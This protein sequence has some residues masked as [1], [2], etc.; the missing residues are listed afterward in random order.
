MIRFLI[1]IVVAVL[2]LGSVGLCQFA[3]TSGLD[4]RFSREVHG[5]GEHQV[6]AATTEYE[7]VVTPSFDAKRDPF[8]LVDDG[9]GDAVRIRIAVEGHELLAWRE[10]V[11]RGVPIRRSG[12][13]IADAKGEWFVEATPSSRDAADACALRIQVYR[14]GVIYEDATVWSE[15]RGAPLARRIAVDLQP[16]RLRLD[17]GLGQGPSA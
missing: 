4:I 5:H 3:L 17:R 10:D 11:A 1:A 16:D 2:L 9:V 12:V 7:L 15:G 13:L 8:Q 14:D 6:E